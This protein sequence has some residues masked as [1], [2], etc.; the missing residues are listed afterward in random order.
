MLLSYPKIPIV[1]T[2][3]RE[4]TFVPSLIRHY[5]E[6]KQNLGKLEEFE[7]FGI[8]GM[9]ETLENIWSKKKCLRRFSSDDYN[10]SGK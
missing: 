4:K 1:K 8:E 10:F 3:L 9:R 2:E 6:E 5:E 7:Q